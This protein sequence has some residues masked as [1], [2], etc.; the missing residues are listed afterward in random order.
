[1][2]YVIYI[3]ELIELI[4][5]GGFWSTKTRE[6]GQNYFYLSELEENGIWVKPTIKSSIMTNPNYGVVFF[7]NPCF[8]DSR[9]LIFSGL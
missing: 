3:F 6:K 8:N 5:P 9:M 4:Q 1:M 7:T 2:Y